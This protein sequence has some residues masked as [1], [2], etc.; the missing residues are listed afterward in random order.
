MDDETFYRVIDQAVEMGFR[1][2]VNLQ[3]FNEPL[4]DPRIAKFAQYAK[5]QGKFAYIHAHTNSDLLTERKAAELDGSFDSLEI[6]LYDDIGGRP[7]G[8][9]ERGERQNL[10]RSWFHKTTVNFTGGAHMITHFSPLAGLQ[11]EIGRNRSKPCIQEV[12]MRCIIDYRGEMLMCCDDIMGAFELGNVSNRSLSDLWWGE[13]H[14]EAMKTLA[15][16][17]GRE[18]F[19]FCQ[20]CP[21]L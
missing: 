2:R 13:P 9:V 7:M 3:H 6:A 4:Q 17:G 18:N 19:P 11:E 16:P 8:I 10:L 1:G 5:D 14:M 20:I 21:R 15:F 12:R